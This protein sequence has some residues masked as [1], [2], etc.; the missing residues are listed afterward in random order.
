MGMEHRML[1]GPVKAMLR[2][3]YPPQCL[4][5]GQIVASG[6]DATPAQH[7]G[8]G[9][10]PGCWQETC[11]ISGL[12]CASCGAPLADDGHCGTQEQEA[13][14]DD[15]LSVA[16]PWH[17]G[18]AAI[19]YSGVGRELVMTLKHGDRPDLAPTLALWLSQA[20]APVIR[21][22]MIVAPVPLHF[23]RLLK[24]RY[25][26]SALLARHL[27]GM[28]GLRHLPHL[29]LRRR[30]TPGQDHRGVADRLAN[31]S[32]AIVINPRRASR[33]AGRQ[34]LLVDDVMTSGATLAAAAEAL[35]AAGS[36]P[37]SVAVLARAVKDA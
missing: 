23:R 16:R 2:M 7:A 17:H 27:A 33:I 36:G 30:H 18:R 34:V 6:P 8:G 20:A 3:L 21:P 26:Q 14:C 10:C 22:G 1:R 15:C 12:A 9:L 13:R 37:V 24:R 19:V 32:G 28:Q 5:C 29:L 31:I 4:S 25:N 11:F 35:L